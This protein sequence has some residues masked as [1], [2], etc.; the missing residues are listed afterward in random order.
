MQIGTVTRNNRKKKYREASKSN[1]IFISILYAGM[2]WWGVQEVKKKTKNK[3]RISL[4]TATDFLKK[5]KTEKR[6]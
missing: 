6:I 3:T 5:K 2:Y 1:L 4:G